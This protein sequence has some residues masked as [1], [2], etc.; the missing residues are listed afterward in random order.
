MYVDVLAA[1]NWQ[2]WLS[3]QP[4]ASFEGLTEQPVTGVH[5]ENVRLPGLSSAAAWDCK[6]VEGVS[7][8]DVHPAP[9]RELRGPGSSAGRSELAYYT[10]FANTFT[11][12]A[13]CV[14]VW[15]R[16]HL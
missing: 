13:S 15:V 2:W 1:A 5:L 16:S 9:C 8:G 7:R 4:A 3:A 10:H 11:L 14:S 6:S 12:A